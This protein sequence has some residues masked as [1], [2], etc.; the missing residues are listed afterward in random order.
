MSTENYNYVNCSLCHS[1]RSRPL[2]CFDYGKAGLKETFV[3]VRCSSCG[4]IYNNPR[5]TTERLNQLYNKDYY[6]FDE[7]WKEKRVWLPALQ[8]YVNK[9][10]PYEAKL[11]AKMLLDIGCGPGFLMKIC[12]DNGWQ[13][14]G[15]DVCAQAVEYGKS[16]FRLNIESGN[17]NEIDF[18]GKKFNLILALDFLEH[19]EDPVAFVRRCY[20]LLQEKGILIM[21][22][23]NIASV[24]KKI[25]GRFWV[26]FNPYHIQF[27]SVDALRRVVE[28]SDFK[29]LD[30]Y[31]TFNDV[32]AKRNLWRWAS[33]QTFLRKAF[34][35][36]WRFKN[37]Y[38]TSQIRC[39]MHEANL[40]YDELKKITDVKKLMEP[41]D[42]FFAKRFLG[43]QLVICLIKE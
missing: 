13:V 29:I 25:T 31:T 6:C 27:F 23:P 18:K 11:P 10:K 2:Y 9:V 16:N 14:E 41:R 38:L 5:L 36:L 34:G 12:R 40:S 33:N 28:Q 1:S 37:K 19:L 8:D 20:D 43:D 24:Y 4:H 42:N 3:L 7:S 21:E 15:I 35:K 30:L 22:M 39:D 17:F 26:G 32:F